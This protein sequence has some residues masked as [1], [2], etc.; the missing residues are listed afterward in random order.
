VREGG[1]PPGS[2][3]EDAVV[4]L[5]GVAAGPPEESAPLG[6]LG[7]KPFYVKQPAR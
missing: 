1:A 6:S 2:V 3:R 5:E 7:A 4:V